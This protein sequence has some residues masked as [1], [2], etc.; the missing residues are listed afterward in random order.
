[1]SEDFLK[2]Q[3]R[4]LTLYTGYEHVRHELLRK[5]RIEAADEN[6]AERIITH[7]LDNRLPNEN[8]FL[9]CPTPA[10][11]KEY[12]RQISAKPNQFKKADKNCPKCCGIGYEITQ[13]GELSGAARCSCT[14]VDPDEPGSHT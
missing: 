8:G 14:R 13:Q 6:H 4:R 5:L 10:E 11:L 1:M 2:N 7:I 12:A 9:N 3:V